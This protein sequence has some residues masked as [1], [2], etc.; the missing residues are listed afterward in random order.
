MTVIGTGVDL[1]FVPDFV[2]QWRMPGTRFEQVFTARERA[3]CGGGASELQAASLAARWAAKEAFIKA[4]SETIW[5]SAPVAADEIHHLIEVIRD[6]WGRPRLVLHGR[7]RELFGDARVF[8][9]LSH[10]GD[11]ATAFVTVEQADP[12]PARLETDFQAWPWSKAH[13]PQGL[14]SGLSG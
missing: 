7:V 5:G 14:V 10:D 4:W 1:V 12:R 9:S 13:I 6:A 3:D 2:E 8:V 11:H